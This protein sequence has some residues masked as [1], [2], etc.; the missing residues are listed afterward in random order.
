MQAKTERTRLTREAVL[1]LGHRYIGLGKR[2]EADNDE[3]R[4]ARW[5]ANKRRYALKEG[6]AMRFTGL[7]K[8]GGHS[9]LRFIGLGKR[10]PAAMR[11]IGLGKRVAGYGDGGFL[12]LDSD[13]MEDINGSQDYYS[14]QDRISKK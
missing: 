5:D 9:G 12:D 4:I 14:I 7:G 13:E 6:S 11:F 8:R 1:P 10:N 3:D 2:L